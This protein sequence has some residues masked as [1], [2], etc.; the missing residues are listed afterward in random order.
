M[1]PKHIEVQI[2]ADK[3]GNVVPSRRARLLPP[4]PL[5]EGGRVRPRLVRARGDASKPCMSDAVKIAKSVGYV[6]AG[7]VEF[8]VDKDGTSLLHRDEPPHSGGAHRH[9]DGHRH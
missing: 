6:N 3:Y 5:S 1:E 8:L 7:T 4:A 9:R 2:L